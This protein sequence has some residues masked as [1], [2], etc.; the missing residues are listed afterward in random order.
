M[1]T[2][3]SLL[4]LTIAAPC[5]HLDLQE[6]IA[7]LFPALAVVVVEDPLVQRCVRAHTR[8]HILPHLNNNQHHS[9]RSHILPQLTMKV[10]TQMTTKTF[11]VAPIVVEE[12]LLQQLADPLLTWA[13]VEVVAMEVAVAVVHQLLLAT[14]VVEEE[15]HLQCKA[16]IKDRGM[17]AIPGD[18]V[19]VAVE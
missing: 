2:N 8:C 11:V 6:S 9:S 17:V 1:G 7:I 15:V 5:Q 16:A 18:A 12:V 19:V 14:F 3:S 10:R 13:V 4:V